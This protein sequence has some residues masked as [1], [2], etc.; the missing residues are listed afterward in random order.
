MQE[1]QH[2][3]HGAPRYTGVA[4]PSKAQGLKN[5]IPK[6]SFPHTAVASSHQ[7]QH[8]QGKKKTNLPVC[9]HRLYP[10]RI[11]VLMACPRHQSQSESG[12]CSQIPTVFSSSQLEAQTGQAGLEGRLHCCTT[13]HNFFNIQVLNQSCSPSLAWHKA[14]GRVFCPLTACPAWALGRAHSTD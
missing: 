7:Q 9:A 1:Q 8:L 12:A 6:I 3:H 5:L 2:Q 4:S 10:S 13:L 14:G 11:P